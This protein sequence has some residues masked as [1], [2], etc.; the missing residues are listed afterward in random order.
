VTNLDAVPLADASSLLDVNE[1]HRA[2]SVVA[3]GTSRGS[4]QSIGLEVVQPGA[5]IL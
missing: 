1:V 4:H 2:D 5:S 3:F